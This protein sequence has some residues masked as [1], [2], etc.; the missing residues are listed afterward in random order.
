MYIKYKAP[1]TL[2]IEIR[3]GSTVIN[4][5]QPNTRIRVWNGSPH[6]KPADNNK[7]DL[8]PFET[9]SL[10][11]NKMSGPGANVNA[12]EAATK[13]KSSSIY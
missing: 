6:T 3:F 4:C 5:P 2:I 1:I 8:E 10:M 11:T 13:E 12:R 9:L 7:P